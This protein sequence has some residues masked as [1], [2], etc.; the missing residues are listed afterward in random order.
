MT[1]KLIFECDDCKRRSKTWKT[2]ERH[3]IAHPD[4]APEGYGLVNVYR[5]DAFNTFN[6]GGVR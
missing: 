3:L 5:Q 2:M 6:L 1:M 4:H